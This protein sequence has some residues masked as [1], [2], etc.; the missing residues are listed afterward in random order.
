MWLSCDRY[1]GKYSP[2]DPLI[3]HSHQE[4]TGSRAD[5]LCVGILMGYTLTEWWRRATVEKQASYPWGP[6]KPENAKSSAQTAA[7]HACVHKQ[8]PSSSCS[9][10]SCQVLLLSSSPL[11]LTGILFLSIS[12]EQSSFCA[13]WIGAMCAQGKGNCIYP[14]MYVSSMLINSVKYLNISNNIYMN[15]N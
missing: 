2:R 14:R 13:L 15:D 7:S 10:A 12:T 5:E 4:K 6:F 11:V 3:C 9:Y 1:L 8:L